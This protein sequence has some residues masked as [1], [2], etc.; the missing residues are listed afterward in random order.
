[1]NDQRPAVNNRYFA[2]LLFNKND[3]QAV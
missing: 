3:D 2:A 1:M